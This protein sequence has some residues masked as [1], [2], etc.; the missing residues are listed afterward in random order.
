MKDSFDYAGKSYPVNDAEYK[1]TGALV[2]ASDMTLPGMLYM[3]LVCSERAHAEI[4][5]VDARAALK[6]RGVAEVFT[7]WNST[8][9]K[10]N[11]CRKTP[12]QQNVPEDK[13]L[14]TSRARYVG[15]V[16]AAVV[17]ESREAAR[18][19]ARRLRVSYRD[20]PVSATFAFLASSKS[21]SAARIHVV[22]SG[23]LSPV[24]WQA[25]SASLSF[26]E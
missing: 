14:F 1:A 9:K 18:E 15:D 2:Y 12:L 25:R 17:A 19:G 20:L 11:H 5:S 10:Y 23:N 16:I 4:T 26:L 24:S 3:E 6:C 21:R 22:I 7:H 8:D 13:E